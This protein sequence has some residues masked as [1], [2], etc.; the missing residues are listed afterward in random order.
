MQLC[1][2]LGP[3]ISNSMPRSLSCPQSLLLSRRAYLLE[4]C[5]FMVDGRIS[6]SD[7]GK[8]IELLCPELLLAEAVEL[9]KHSM[10]KMAQVQQL[11]LPEALDIQKKTL[12]MVAERHVAKAV[13]HW[14]QL[15][16]FE[17]LKLLSEALD[18]LKKPR[19]DAQIHLAAAKSVWPW[20]AFCLHWTQ[21][22]CFHWL[23]LCHGPA[24]LHMPAARSVPV[25][26]PMASKD[27]SACRLSYACRA[28]GFR[29]ELQRIVLGAEPNCMSRQRTTPSVESISALLGCC[30]RCMTTWPAM[31]QRPQVPALRR[32]PVDLPDS[33]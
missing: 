21:M 6:D 12:R 10:A 19:T 20:E 15:H 13:C 32:S 26:L 4:F 11:M 7:T 16:C 31:F 18:S 33:P 30:R 28:P 22:H 27:R 23:L 14:T 5:Q 29:S 9:A 17:W 3:N 2:I 8:P 25:E 24:I 1:G